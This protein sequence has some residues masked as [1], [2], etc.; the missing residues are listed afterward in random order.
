MK[1]NVEYVEGIPWEMDEYYFRKN[2][3]NLIILDDLINEALKSLKITQ[4]FTRGR[5]NNIFVIYLT[6]K[7]FRKNQRAISLNSNY[8]VIFKNTHNLT[9]HNL[10]LLKGK[11]IR[12]LWS[13]LCGLTKMQHHLRIQTWCL[14]LNLTKGIEWEASFWKIHNM[15]I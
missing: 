10:L 6:L 2:K 9:I 15:S 1:M 8:M 3:R 14:I 11:Y 12:I 7:L 4:L 5:H 13:F